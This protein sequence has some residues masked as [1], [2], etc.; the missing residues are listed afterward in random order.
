MIWKDLQD[1]LK[2][3]NTVYSEAPFIWG[4]QMAWKKTE[5]LG[6]WGIIGKEFV[7]PCVMVAIMEMSAQTCWYRSSQMVTSDAAFWIDKQIHSHTG[8]AFLR[9]LRAKDR[10]TSATLVPP[11]LTGNYLALL[12]NVSFEGKLWPT[13]TAY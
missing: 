5:W 8:H 11:P 2:N 10:A 3:K 13:W 1:R 9:S 4:K 7:F 12:N 6:N